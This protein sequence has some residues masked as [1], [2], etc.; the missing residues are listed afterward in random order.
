MDAGLASL[1]IHLGGEVSVLRHQEFLQSV[2]CRVEALRGSI[3]DP[4]DH[5]VRFAVVVTSHDATLV[6]RRALPL[7]WTGLSPVGPRQL[8]LAHQDTPH[9]LY[10]CAAYDRALKSGQ[11]LSHLRARWFCWPCSASPW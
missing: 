10:Q 1:H 11:F 9:T 7:T 8:R 6:T 2:A 5:C 3:P 4:H